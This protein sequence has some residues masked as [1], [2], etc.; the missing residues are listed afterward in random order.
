ME[1]PEPALIRAAA[2]GDLTAFE[3]LVRAYQQHVWRFLSRLLAD[4]AAAEDVTQETF[5]RVFRRLP[6]FTFEAKFSTWVFQIA[7]NAGIDELRSRERRNRL[8]SVAPP[9]MSV[10]PPEARAEIEAALASLPVD[11]R[12]AVVLVEVLGLRYH[13]VARV[14]GVPEGTVKSRMFSA[15]SRLHRWSTAD[16]E[17]ASG[18][19]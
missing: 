19:V 2:A 10:A 1:E 8:A 11:L 3:Q 15:R 4:A 9:G 17:S 7:R 5:L 18:E 16:E 12:E 13:E 14:I 6:T